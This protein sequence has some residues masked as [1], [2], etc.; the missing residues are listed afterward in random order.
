MTEQNALF[1]FDSR[2]DDTDNVTVAVSTGTEV[3][4]MPVSNLRLTDRSLPA[5]VTMS[6]NVAVIDI[7]LPGA[8]TVDTLGLVDC[9]ITTAGT[10]RL[11]GWSDALRGAT[12]VYDSTAVAAPIPTPSD[13][14][15]SVYGSG[16]YG[17]GSYGAGTTL[18][19]DIDRSVYL[20]DLGAEYSAQY[21][22]LTI[23]DT[24]LS[25]AQIA[26]V[27]LSLRKQYT[28]NLSYNFVKTADS[29][30][31]VR[32]AL[33]GARWRSLKA[34]R[35]KLSARYEMQTDTAAD[36]IDLYARQFGQEIPFIFCARP[37][38]NNNRM[39]ASAIYG[40]F[41][42]PTSSPTDYDMNTFA[43]SISEEL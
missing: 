1:L 14:T 10:Y 21:W 43:F 18:P 27:Y 3:S 30:T 42:G 28:T 12:L 2:M 19:D 33:G 24:N 34:Q 39:A 7:T 40:V 13:Y 5:R 4:A 29:R 17:M 37:F 16:S 32:E 15:A 38:G 35:R 11:R 6:S 26:R 36:E 9:N 20:V 8:R 31:R 25:Y 23:S 22:E 41:D